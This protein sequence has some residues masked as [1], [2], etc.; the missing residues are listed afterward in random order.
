MLSGIRVSPCPCGTP[1]RWAGQT[2]LL[3]TALYQQTLDRRG[4]VPVPA[5]WDSSSPCLHPAERK[6]SL[7]RG[8]YEALCCVGPAAGFLEARKRGPILHWKATFRR[9]LRMLICL[10]GPL[11]PPP[12]PRCCGGYLRLCLL[13]NGGGRLGLYPG[14][15]DPNFKPWPGCHCCQC[16]LS[17]NEDLL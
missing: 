17:R 16:P 5:A 11:C 7:V 14:F 8:K 12:A 2:T 3:C 6:N 1:A 15:S 4:A 13:Q 10:P 9:T